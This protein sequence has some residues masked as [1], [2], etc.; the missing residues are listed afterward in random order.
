MLLPQR[1]AQFQVPPC[2]AVQHHI[3]SRGVGRNTGHEGQIVLLCLQKVAK[4]C[5]R[6]DDARVQISQ[7]QPVQCLHLKMLQKVLSAHPIVKIPGIQRIQRDLKPFLEVFQIHPAHIK[8]LVADDLG[9]AESGDLVLKLSAVGQLR[10]EVIPCGHIRHRNPVTVRQVYDTH[11]IIIFGFIHH[12]AVQDRARRD[13]PNHLPPDQPFGLLRVFCLLADGHLVALCHQTVQIP[14]HGMI[15]DAA[16]GRPFIQPAAF[17]GQ[18]QLQF[19]GHCN[20]VLEEHLIEIPQPVKQDAAGVFL[21]RI[22]IF[23][24]HW[25]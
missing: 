23:L 21:F 1:F 9:R 6:A 3:F 18:G 7:P 14:V 24:H 2:G 16:H 15:R 25:C 8:R 19:P 13:H 5:P 11:D 12:L 17:P 4:Q 20:C 10:H 22:H